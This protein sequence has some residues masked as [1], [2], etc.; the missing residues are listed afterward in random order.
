MF[1]PNCGKEL[2]KGYCSNCGYNDAIQQTNQQILKPAQV[3]NFNNSFVAA[4]NTSKKKGMIIACLSAVG[5][6]A[7]LMIFAMIM[8]W[9]AD[10]SIKQDIENDKKT[11]APPSFHKK[12]IWEFED[13]TVTLKKVELD[14]TAITESFTGSFDIVLLVENNSDK[15]ISISTDS[16]NINGFTIYTDYGIVAEAAPS[17]KATGSI[18]ISSSDLLDAGINKV[19]DIQLYLHAFSDDDWLF[20]EESGCITIKSDD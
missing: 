12:V 5:G 7:L 1:C 20:S 16:V 10:L 13:V 15:D 11:V 6:F 3:N 2:N 19:E 9:A 14:K 8:E 4:K 17:S 18:H